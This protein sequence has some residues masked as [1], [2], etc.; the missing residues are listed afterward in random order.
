MLFDF[1]AVKCCLFVLVSL[2]QCGAC[3]LAPPSAETPTCCRYCHALL[4]SALLYSVLEFK[5]PENCAFFMGDKYAKLELVFYEV[6]GAVVLIGVVKWLQWEYKLL[7]V[8]IVPN[9][10]LT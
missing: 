2:A 8:C 4:C 3:L 10:H 5:R 6:I 7:Y 1:L 9:P